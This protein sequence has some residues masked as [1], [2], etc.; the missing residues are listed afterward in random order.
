[1]ARES[2]LPVEQ[3]VSPRTAEATEQLADRSFDRLAGGCLPRVSGVGYDAYTRP[4][5]EQVKAVSVYP[6]LLP[7]EHEGL[8]GETPA[9]RQGFTDHVSSLAEVLS[10]RS[11]PVTNP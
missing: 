7:R 1:M 3:L 4:L 8:K 5:S 11:A 6:L 9:M 2:R 10:Y